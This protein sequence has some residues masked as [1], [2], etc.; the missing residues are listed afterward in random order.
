MLAHAGSYGIRS[1]LREKWDEEGV[2]KRLM[3]L[4]IAIYGC[5]SV[6]LGGAFVLGS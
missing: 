5:F 1:C 2:S 6:G 3:S 4:H